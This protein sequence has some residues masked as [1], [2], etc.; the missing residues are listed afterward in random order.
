MRILHIISSLEVGGAQKLLANLLPL[1]AQGHSVTLLVNTD[2]GGSFTSRV[3]AAGINIIESRLPVYSWRNIFFI[4]RLLDGYD[5]VHVHLFPTVYWAA[6]ASLFKRSRMVY[7]EHSTSNRRRGKWY[8]RPI[9]QWVYSRF[10]KV[11]SISSQTQQALTAW[12]RAGD[13]DARFVTICNGIDLTAFPMA[14][15][16]CHTPRTLIQVSRFEAAKDQ[17]TVI[18]AMTLLPDNMQLLLVGDGSR[19]AE[20]KQLAET[21]TC[22]QR[23]RFLG[24][25]SDIAALLQQAD[26]AV[27]SSHWEGFGLTAVE[28]MACG[29]P[30]IASDV[31]GLRQVV[32]GSGLLFTSGDA[33]MLA[34]Q[35]MQIVGDPARYEELSTKSVQ[36]ASQYDIRTM[37]EAYL[38]LYGEI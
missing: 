35:V 36:R 28:A 37:A 13:G 25:R 18:R 2:V 12:L 29:L 16:Q 11:I 22:S 6:C 27:Q 17:D 30:V 32:E 15:R 21:L 19:L 8:F 34:E 5:I 31:D 9:E 38:A 4:R 26:I 33:A 3:K 7:T 10:L 1:L 14:P 20:C 23:I 24:A